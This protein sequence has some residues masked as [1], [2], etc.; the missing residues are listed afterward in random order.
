MISRGSWWLVLL[1]WASASSLFA[2]KVVSITSPTNQA[3]F[4]K[5][6]GMEVN[7]RLGAQVLNPGPNNVRVYFYANGME[8][9]SASTLEGYSTTW[10]NVGFGTHVVTAVEAQGT[11]ATNSVIIHV[12]TNGVALVSETAVWKYLDG[13]A[14]PASDWREPQADLSL[15]LSGVPQFGFG[16]G[17]E[18]TVV[19]WLNLTNGSVYP[20]YYFRHAFILSNAV[21]HTNLLVRLLRDDGAIV[22]LNGQEL[23]R[24]NMPAGT[25]NNGTFATMSASDENVFNDRWV[26][27]AALVEG[28]NHLAVQIHNQGPQSHDISFDLRLLANLPVSAPQLT[29]KWLETNL[30]AAWPRSYLGYRLEAAAELGTND[31]VTVTN[32]A[33]SADEFRW[34]IPLTLPARFFRLSL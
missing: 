8:V 13:G 22:Y 31:W 10:S 33:R 16:D 28:A 17:D 26:R 25:V 5:S 21:S 19:N 15:W 4:A 7:V 6:V 3:R 30:V 2:Q 29:L 32:V 1:V 34:V 18:Q 11:P 12:E 23:F 27:P 20:A 9:G 14:E 24:D